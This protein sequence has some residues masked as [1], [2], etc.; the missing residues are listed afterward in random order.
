MDRVKMQDFMVPFIDLTVPAGFPSP[1]AEFAERR[2]NL[3]ME[4]IQHP[5]ATY[6]VR[7]AGDSMINA[8]IPPKCLLVV[9]RAIEAKN[10]DIVVVFINGDWTVKR[11]EKNEHR[12]R[13]VPEN[14]KYKEIT[15]T[16]DMEVLIWGVVIHII[17]TPKRKSNGGIGGL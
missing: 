6:I 7:C 4:L 17:S 15:I 10:G 14:S 13:L 16:D 9:D 11:L 2:I 3:N 5:E 8:F 1:A 12:S